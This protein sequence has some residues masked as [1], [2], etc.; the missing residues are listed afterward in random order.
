LLKLCLNSILV[1]I[2]LANYHSLFFH[3]WMT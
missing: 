2:A 3:S 1:V